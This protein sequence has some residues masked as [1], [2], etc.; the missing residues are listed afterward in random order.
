MFNVRLAGGHLYGK[1]LFTWLS[2]VVSFMTSFVLSFFPLDV[3]DGIWDLTES[4]S[5]GFLTYS[6]PPCTKMVFIGVYFNTEDLTL[7]ITPDR[8]RE[9]LD[10]IDLWSKKD[11]AL[12]QKLQSLIGKLSFIVPCVHSSRIIICRLYNWLSEI[13]SCVLAEQKK[14]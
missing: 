11:S 6:C 10:L 3:L 4:V 8:V 12:L 9:T 7:S 2:L 5:E 1:Q 13:H 14:I